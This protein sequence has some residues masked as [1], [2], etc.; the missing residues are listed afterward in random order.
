M[1]GS[2]GRCSWT[3]AEGRDVPTSRILL[4]S[5]QCA[6]GDKRSRVENVAK[7]LVELKVQRKMSNMYTLQG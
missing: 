5:P 6:V 3:L 2:E 4:Q 7:V 1:D